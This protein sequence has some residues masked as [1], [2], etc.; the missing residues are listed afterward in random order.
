MSSGRSNVEHKPL[1]NVIVVN[2][3]GAMF[4]YAEDFSE[5]RESVKQLQISDWSY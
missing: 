3:Y 2:S 4:M 1:I 5:W